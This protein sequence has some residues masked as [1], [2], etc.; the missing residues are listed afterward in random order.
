[1][2]RTKA[3]GLHSDV[4]VMYNGRGCSMARTKAGGLHSDVIVMYNDV[5]WQGQRLVG[6]TVT[7]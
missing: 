5:A 6:C 3:G 7:S 4:I 2:A 1:M